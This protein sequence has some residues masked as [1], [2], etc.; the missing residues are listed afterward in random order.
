MYTVVRRFFSHLPSQP[1]QLLDQAFAPLFGRGGIPEPKHMGLTLRKE[2]LKHEL[3]TAL[4]HKTIIEQSPLGA[5]IRAIPSTLTW[6]EKLKRTKALLSDGAMPVLTPHPTRVLSND[7][8]REL[9][10]LIERFA[11]RSQQASPEEEAALITS[12]RQWAEG[13]LVPEKPMAPQAESDFSRFINLQIQDSFPKFHAD[14]THLF[15]EAHGGDRV[16]V[17]GYLKEPAMASFKQVLD[18]DADRDGNQNRTAKTMQETVPAQQKAILSLYTLRLERIL[19]KIDKATAPEEV[20]T[21]QSIHAFFARCEESISDGIWFDVKGSNQ[22]KART[23]TKLAAVAATLQTHESE[24]QR[25]IADDV[26]ALRDLV[27]LVGYYGGLKHYARQTTQLYQRVLDDLLNVLKDYHPELRK[28]GHYQDLSPEEKQAF[29]RK[30]DS[31][32]R[33]FKTLKDNQALFNSETATELECL[34]F[35]L[36]HIDLYPHII[37]SDTKSALNLRE[38][39]ILFSLAAF[40]NGDLRIGQTKSY[41]AN[42]MILCESPEDIQSF[43]T[44][45]ATILAD[46]LIQNKIAE[47]YFFSYV[48][49]PS[50]LGKTGG[51]LT[52]ITLLET[53][54]EAEKQFQYDAHWLH[55]LRGFGG[56]LFRKLGSA[57]NEKHS[58]NQGW[59]A[60]VNLGAPDA[61]R[62]YLHNVVGRA[63]ESE[64]RAKEIDTLKITNPDAY[65]ALKDIEAACIKAY[66][67]H[68]NAPETSALLSA[69]TSPNI[70]KA[71]NISSRAG[72]KQKTLRAIG[73]NSQQALARHW[74]HVFMGLEGLIDVPS[75][76]R[77]HL[78]TLL[79][80]LTVVKDIVYKVLFAIAISDFNRSE[81]RIHGCADSEIDALLQTHAHIR[82]TARSILYLVVLF[83]EGKVRDEAQTYLLNHGHL[84]P[85]RVALALMR[86]LSDETRAL[87]RDTESHFH[88]HRLL[89]SSVDAYEAN[90][91]AQTLENAVLALRAL[92]VVT[93]PEFFINLRS[94]L[95]KVNLDEASE[96]KSFAP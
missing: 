26:L 61:Y 9:R 90:P 10:T 27:D 37:F 52:Y 79:N 75:D 33:Y 91:T 7:K 5:S 8:T 93:G 87:A 17:A 31:H 1:T 19:Q 65:D 84:Q 94:P 72:A 46:P 55:I 21:L 92:P 59:D 24:T 49:G 38:L 73:W 60:Y 20:N 82:S 78:P 57:F 36:K 50:D 51:I 12:V 71:A 70:E 16:M 44:T 25:A 68:I 18:W 56:D 48:G 58:T 83:Y 85:N 53:F 40:L 63:S 86:I 74:S 80:D 45:L 13:R 11:Q 76:K 22:N 67:A 30:L 89:E 42:P 54:L 34:A 43:K 3:Q 35:F 29:L 2:I 14:V 64:L 66:E 88:Y 4:R 81:Q 95:S 32:S 6:Q 41:P 15:I 62:S 23:M 39:L 69:L 77:Q 47:S 96:V 28:T